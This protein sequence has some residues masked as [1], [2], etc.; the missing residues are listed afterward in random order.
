MWNDYQHLVVRHEGDVLVI[1][2]I[3]PKLFDTTTVTQLQDELLSLVDAERPDKAIVD[4]G[5][6]VHCS[7]AVING[8]LRAKK[9]ILANGG[10]LKLCGMTSGIRDAYRMLNLDGTVFQIHDNVENAVLAF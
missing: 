4:F 1:E 6:V 7:T 2:L 3:D 10:R 8:L 9:R 5:R